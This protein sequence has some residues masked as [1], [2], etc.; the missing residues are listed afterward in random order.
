MGRELKFRAWDGERYWLNIVPSPIPSRTI[1]VCAEIT[2]Y[3][4]EYYNMVDIIEG[5]ET[6]E[7]YTGLEDKNGKGIYEGDF[8]KL[9][10]KETRIRNKPDVCEGVFTKYKEKHEG[11]YEITFN[12]NW[13]AFVLTIPDTNIVE[14]SLGDVKY[15]IE[16]I[17][18]I[19]ENPELFGGEK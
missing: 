18:N 7:Q 1:D 4:P 19:H 3:E 5:V 14:E 12:K 6:V 8:V 10:R 9:C 16:V 17:G 2:G 15:S 13:S 11:I